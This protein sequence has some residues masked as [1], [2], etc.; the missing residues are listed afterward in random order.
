VWKIKRERWYLQKAVWRIFSLFRLY[1]RKATVL[2]TTV[3][4]VTDVS[5]RGSKD[6]TVK[7]TASLNGKPAANPLGITLL[8]D[9]VSCTSSFVLKKQIL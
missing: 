4:F 1:V 9:F 8:K 2:T 6:S 5:A 3:L 7:D